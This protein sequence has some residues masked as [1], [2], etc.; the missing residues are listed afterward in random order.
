MIRICHIASADLWAGAEVYVLGLLKHL[1]KAGEFSL[2]VIVFNE[3]RLAKELRESGIDVELIDENKQGLSRMFME[4]TRLLKTRRYHIVHTHK[5]KDNILGV[6]AGKWAGVPIFVRT[7]HGC[8]EPFAGLEGIRMRASEYIDALITKHLSSR[9]IMVSQNLSQVLGSTYTSGQMVCIHNGIDIESV[10]A[11][12]G[13]SRIRSEWGVANS[14]PVIGVVG[15][16][17]RIK[18][19]E[20]LLRAIARINAGTSNFKVIVIGDGPERIKLQE[21]A[22][23][24]GIDNIIRFI[25]HR[26]DVYDCIDA[27]D[28]LALPS[29]HEGLPMVLLEAMALGCPVI[30]SRI[31]GIPEVIEHGKSGLLFSAGND[32]ELA[33][34]IVFLLGDR[35][36]SIRLGKEGRERVR[37]HFN[38][39]LMAMHT[40]QVYKLLVHSSARS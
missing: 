19:Q 36:G 34:Y 17:T 3:G 4:L 23:I 32:K 14:L 21:L 26:D 13:R 33:D 24:L 39:E 35:K 12:T 22:T 16:L 37:T 18:G 28:I 40:A 38:A 11:H 30:A 15:R 29:L 31:G 1:I 20:V 5:P 10:Q 9:V 8:P 25:G 7:I 27:L 2:S 6:M